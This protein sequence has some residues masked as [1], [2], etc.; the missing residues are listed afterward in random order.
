MHAN[1]LHIAGKSIRQLNS[2]HLLLPSDFRGAG[3]STNKPTP[4]Q[5]SQDPFPKANF[6]DLGANRTVKVVVIA[7]LAVIATAE[8]IAWTK[9]LWGKFGPKSEKGAGGDE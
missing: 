7:S 4:N 3:Y 9:F 5:N 6:K 8:T 1:T 2:Q